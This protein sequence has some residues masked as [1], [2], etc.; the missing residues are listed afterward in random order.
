[1]DVDYEVPPEVEPERDG[2]DATATR[3]SLLPAA[4]LGTAVLLVWRFAG[5]RLLRG[6][7]D[8][9]GWVE[10]VV[11][12]VLPTVFILAY[13]MWIIRRAGG[14]VFGAWPGWRLLLIEAGIAMLALVCVQIF[15][16]L[17]AMIY[18]LVNGR[19][20]GVP[21]Q[22]QEMAAGGNLLTLALMAVLACVWAPVA[23]ELFFRR[24]LL[25][26]LAGRFSLAVAIGLQAFVFAILHDYGGMHLGAIFVLGLTM[27]GLYAWRKTIVT[28][29][30][31]HML[32]NTFAIAILG[33]FM[34]LS[35]VGPTLGVYGE[36]HA[37]GLKIVEVAP[38]TPAAEAGLQVGDIITEVEGNKVPDAMTLRLMYWAAG[39]DGK[40]ELKVQR[41]A[42]TIEV[43][44]RPK[45]EKVK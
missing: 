34:L 11:G 6:D 7:A 35:R 1:M 36:P 30:I 8:E 39:L 33:L 15:N 29:M 32:Q 25:R 2:W 14:R 5:V 23:E 20:P 40:A 27:G 3:A 16:M 24:F 44:V 18:T 10:V 13:P 22:F 45:A 4:L 12:G 17:L 19:G 37:D 38:D 21:E 9:A 43:D 28:S 31:L 26:A 41:G 42:E